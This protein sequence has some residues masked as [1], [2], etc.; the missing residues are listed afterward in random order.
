V[1]NILTRWSAWINTRRK[2]V[3]LMLLVLVVAVLVIV[4]TPVFLIMP[5]KAQTPRTMEVSYLMRRW[6]PLFTLA[7][8]A[9][10]LIFTI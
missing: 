8:S 7:A 5:F 1:T 3:W 2:L 6:S 10:I 4:L 9:C